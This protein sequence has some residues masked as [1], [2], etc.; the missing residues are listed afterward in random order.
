MVAEGGMSVRTL[1]FCV[2]VIHM[3][4]ALPQEEKT[5]QHCVLVLPTGS[6]EGVWQLWLR[7]GERDTLIQNN[8]TP[9]RDG[10]LTVSGL[11]APEQGQCYRFRM[12]GAGEG[13]YFDPTP[14]QPVMA[15]Y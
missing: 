5:G 6:S 8:L 4:M 12:I 3:L 9:D 15:P 1:L 2:L 14:H 13:Q 10:V 7:E 11:P